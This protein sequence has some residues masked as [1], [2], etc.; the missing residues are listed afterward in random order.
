M[1]G[2]R[3]RKR[4]ASLHSLT[5]RDRSRWNR[6]C[7]R[8]WGGKSPSRE[9]QVQCPLPGLDSH[10]AVLRRR[11]YARHR[12]FAHRSV[13]HRPEIPG[14]LRDPTLRKTSPYRRPQLSPLRPEE[15]LREHKLDI[16][17]IVRR[18]NRKPTIR[19]WL[20]CCLYRLPKICSRQNR[21]RNQ[22]GGAGGI[23]ALPG[24]SVDPKDCVMNAAWADCYGLMKGVEW[25]H[26]GCRRVGASQCRNGV[27][28]LG[29]NVNA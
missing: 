29:G 4:Q 7:E 26:P 19:S 8:E 17:A 24:K 12:S 18:L 16:P 27:R 14:H 10:P 22:S 9:T 1:P 3:G 2:S 11:I 28:Y 15:I 13:R 21:G 25:P 23:A 20:V 6:H 5:K